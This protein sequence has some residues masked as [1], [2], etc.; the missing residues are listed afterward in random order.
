MFWWGTNTQADSHCLHQNFICQ[1]TKGYGNLIH[2][3]RLFSLS[4]W[5]PAS[6]FLASAA[7]LTLAAFKACSLAS[8]L[9]ALLSLLAALLALLAAFL[10]ALWMKWYSRCTSQVLTHLYIG[11]KR[12]SK[13]IQMACLLWWTVWAV[14]HLGCN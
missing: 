9:L 8:L 4:L 12:L 6:K 13:A 14:K 10:S 3:P 5:K 7:W 11:Y 2:L 1:S